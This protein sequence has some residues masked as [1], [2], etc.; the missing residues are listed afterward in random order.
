MTAAISAGAP[1]HPD[2]MWL[3]ADWLRIKEEAKRLQARIAKARMVGRWG[4][5]PP[6]KSSTS[7]PNF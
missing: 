7:S 5:V 2:M 1:S 4:K 3:Q 6:R